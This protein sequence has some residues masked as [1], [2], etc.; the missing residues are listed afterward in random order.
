VPPGRSGA[1]A[2]TSEHDDR[3]TYSIIGRDP[4]TGAT[5]IA[6]QSR[7]F[8]A[9]QDLAWIEPGVGAVCTQALTD[10]SY[11][12]RG[13]ALMREGRSPADALAEATAADEGREIR[14]VA[15]MDM[16]GNVAQHTG[17]ACVEAAGHVVG[18]DCCA[19][20]NMLVSDTCWHAMVAAFA[21]TAGDLVDRLLA[22][23][24]A[25]EREGGDARGRQA[26]RILVRP[27]QATGVQW[28]DRIVDLYVIDHPAPVPELRRLVD[29]RRAYDRIG[30]AFD[31][32]RA[33][34]HA[35]AA[36]E[37]DRAQRLAPDD[38]QIAFW[39][40]TILGAAGRTDDAAEAWLAA[41]AAHPGWPD[42]LR[43]C[44]A[45]GLL[46]PEATALLDVRA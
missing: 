19:Q 1:R 20:G 33:G 16:E 15:Y 2:G 17:A 38:D 31:R 36:D 40:A 30:T 22:A 45:A 6:V 5:G 24:D 27:A 9:G 25:A 29:V 10:P 34:D 32:S 39:R 35:A 4:A 21:D 13:L 37:A 7:W 23:L 14:Q 28:E 41:T 3:V 11:G 44:V 8:H 12:P 26:A 43:R 42:Y 46:P 18:R